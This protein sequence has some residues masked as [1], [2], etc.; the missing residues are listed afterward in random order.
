M[1]VVRENNEIKISIPANLFEMDEI[2][3]FLDY[4]RIRE[5]TSK[6]NATQEDADKL[7]NEINQSWWDKN[8]YKFETYLFH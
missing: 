4:I 6:S 1:R 7:A 3:K 8:K 5:I 2:Q